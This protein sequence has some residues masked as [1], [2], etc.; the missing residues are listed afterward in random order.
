MT[1]NEL[2]EKL[3]DKCDVLQMWL[4]EY[5]GIIAVIQDSKTTLEERKELT[6]DKNNMFNNIRGFIWGVYSAGMITYDDTVKLIKELLKI[7]KKE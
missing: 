4:D 7:G 6:L 5:E 3:E 1:L 2:A